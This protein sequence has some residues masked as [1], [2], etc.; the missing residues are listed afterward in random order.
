MKTFILK[1]NPTISSIDMEDMHWE[2]EDSAC[3]IHSTFN[4]SVFEWEK[5]E[6]GD[7]VFMLLVGQEKNNGIVGAGWFS[8]KP[9]EADDW[10]GS[11]HKRY[12][13]D[14]V[15]EAMVHPECIL[16]LATQIL[17]E[18]IPTVEWT[19]GHSGVVIEDEES[20][21]LEKLWKE[22]KDAHIQEIDEQE[23]A[24]AFLC[25]PGMAYGIAVNAHKGQVDKAGKDYFT[26]HVMEVYRMVDA[27]FDKD[28]KV[29]V[30]EVVALLHDV[31]EDTPCTFEQLK[32]LGFS[33]EVLDALR[34][35]TKQEG[36]DYDHFIERCLT[37][38]VAR[39]VK[40]ADLKNNMDITRLNEITDKDVEISSLC[41]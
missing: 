33:D 21:A 10:A 35:V 26:A 37:N 18:S 11:D 5:A 32:T 6:V 9:Y 34:C 16:P 4:W 28:D 1:W 41:H 3:D 29:C 20:S 24:N 36:E 23:D 2:M 30:S 13:C 8:S 12:Y 38:P 19:G 15:W 40:I 25:F 27:V 39:A 14:I 17:Q 7:R 22:Y 31:V